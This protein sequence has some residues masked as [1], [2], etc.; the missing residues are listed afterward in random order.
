MTARYWQDLTTEDVAAL[1]IERA[2]VVLPVGAIEQHGPHLP[3]STDALI[4]EAM[5]TRAAELLPED[6]AIYLLPMLPVGL[7]LEHTGFPGT[8]TLTA[9]T[10][11]AV[12]REIGAS[13]AAAGIRK[14]AMVNCHGGQ[15][16]IL[17]L[18]AQSLRHDHGM[19]AVK[20]NAYRFLRDPGIF[21][22]DEIRHGIHGGAIETSVVLHLRPDLVRKDRIA[23]FATRSRAADGKAL[24]PFGDAAYAWQAEDLT[25][26]GAAG[27][28]RLA[29]A[30]KGRE[31]FEGAATR[32]AA[33]LQEV[34]D[35]RVGDLIAQPGPGRP[36]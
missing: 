20:I 1:D 22:D 14:I 30:G 8:L 26:T 31:L 28:A 35:A 9:E 36:R 21:P 13:V 16:Q 2:V 34:A 4:C 12:L 5:A 29:D 17:D 10:L 18:A 11:L 25:P 27:D 24:S 6:A 3:L 7:S 19:L 15:P 33:A 23:E 32:L